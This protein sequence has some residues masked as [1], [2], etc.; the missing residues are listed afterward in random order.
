VPHPGTLPEP[1]LR[2]A[3]IE[4]ILR[5]VPIAWAGLERVALS[6]VDLGGVTVPAGSTV[7]R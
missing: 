7:I 4:E 3:A 5:Y 1:E 2:P 6:D